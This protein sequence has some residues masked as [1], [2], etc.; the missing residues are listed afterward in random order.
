LFPCETCGERGD[1]T[2]HDFN[3]PHFRSLSV[4]E[5]V[6]ASLERNAFVTARDAD[7]A[8]FTQEEYLRRQRDRTLGRWRRFGGSRRG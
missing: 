1:I 3:A 4:E 7:A 8:G 5:S 6:I 2:F